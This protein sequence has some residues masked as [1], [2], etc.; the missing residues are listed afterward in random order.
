VAGLG[1]EHLDNPGWRRHGQHRACRM[2]PRLGQTPRALLDA[3]DRALYRAKREG[4]NRVAVDAGPSRWPP[5]RGLAGGAQ[6]CRTATGILAERASQ[7]DTSA[8]D[9]RDE[10]GKPIPASR[11]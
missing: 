1:I 7:S 4:R 11:T 3:A 8:V 10:G 6:R 5:S 9:Y 2:K